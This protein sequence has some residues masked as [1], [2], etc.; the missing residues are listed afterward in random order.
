MAIGEVDDAAALELGDRFY[1]VA[2]FPAIPRFDLDEHNRRAVARDDVEF[3]AAG[4]IAAGKNCVPA[5]FEL[6]TREILAQFPEI[7]A[8]S[9]HGQRASNPGATAAQAR[10]PTL[11][12]RARTLNAR[13]Y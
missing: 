3:A 5:P 2:K 10:L 12:A 1:S 11:N 4:T 8:G 9:R 6:A 13:T 7:L